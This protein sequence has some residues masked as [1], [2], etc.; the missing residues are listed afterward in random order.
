MRAL[1]VFIHQMQIVQMVDSTVPTTREFWRRTYFDATD[2][3]AR[4]P[5][6]FA[7]VLESRAVLTHQQAKEAV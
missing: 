7:E 5:R 1:L 6:P 4:D 2:D 3:E